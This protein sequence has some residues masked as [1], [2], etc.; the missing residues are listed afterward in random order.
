METAS[1]SG[2]FGP[3]VQYEK[4]GIH[5]VFPRFPYFRLGQNTGRISL[6]HY[7]VLPLFSFS[8]IAFLQK[9]RQGDAFKEIIDH[10]IQLIPHGPGLTAGAAGAGA[11]VASGAGAG[12]LASCLTGAGRP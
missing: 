8:G 9:I 2:S 1:F 6:P 3:I 4:W 7:A 12:A 11:G 5:P 10:L